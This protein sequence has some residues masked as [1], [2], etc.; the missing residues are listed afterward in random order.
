M[1]KVN[2]HEK[3]IY[4]YIYCIHLYIYIGNSHIKVDHG[5]CDRIYII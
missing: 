3:Q 5:G 1:H 2:I 4:I